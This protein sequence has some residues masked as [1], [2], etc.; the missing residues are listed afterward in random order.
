MADDLAADN[1]VADHDSVILWI[2]LKNL[3]VCARSATIVVAS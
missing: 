1:I 3:L 2:S